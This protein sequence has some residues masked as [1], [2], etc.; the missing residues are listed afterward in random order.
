M[1]MEE[2][3]DIARQLG[4][5]G[6]DVIEAGFPAASP[7]DLESVRQVALEVRGPIICGLARANKGD[8][9]SC[10]EAVKHAEK[11]RI[12][13]FLASSDIHLHHKLRM[14]REEALEQATRRH[15]DPT[16]G[17]GRQGIHCFG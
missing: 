12:H 4:R 17:G 14:S 15:A 2:K 5:L 11:P 7:G 8:I 10:W 13:V 3:M 6:V 1:T 16:G 9:D